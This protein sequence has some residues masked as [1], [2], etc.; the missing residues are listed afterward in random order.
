M[1][2]LLTGSSGWL[3]QTLAPRLRALGHMV[4]GLDPVAVAAYPAGRLDCR[5]RPRPARDRRQSA[6]RRSSTAARCTSPTSSGAPRE[7]F[8]DVNIRGTFNLLEEAVANG[9]GRFVFTSTTSLMISEAIRAGLAGG[10]AARGVAYRGNGPRAAQ[11]LWR[12]QALGRASLPALSPAVRAAGHRAAHR[13]V[14]PRRRR[15]GARDRAVG[16]E[17]QGQRIPVPPPRPS[18]MRPRPMSSRWRRRPTI[19]FD[20]F[21]ISAPTPFSPDDCEAADRRCAE[22]RWR[23]TSRTIRAS[24]RARAGPCSGRSTA[25][26]TPRGPGRGWAFVCRT[27]FA[28]VLAG[29]RESRPI[30]GDLASRLERRGGLSQRRRQSP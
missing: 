7:D 22:R 24:M 2:I 20:T 3:G 18:R 10:A 23:A 6:S 26:T 1:R 11:H 12:H 29:W 19:G 4:I 9:V 8:I 15:H 13:A 27:G 30:V 16:R 25:S 28:D 5:P 17:H 14:L 21:I